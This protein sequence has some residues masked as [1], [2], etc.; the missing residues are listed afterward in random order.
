MCCVLGCL[1][2][3]S[4]VMRLFRPLPPVQTIAGATNAHAG[5]RAAAPAGRGTG[6]RLERFAEAGDGL[7]ARFDF[8]VDMR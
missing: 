8:V 5:R 4:K 6:M 2:I 1:F 3:V 7:S